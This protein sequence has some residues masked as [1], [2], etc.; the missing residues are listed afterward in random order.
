MQSAENLLELSLGEQS[1]QQSF[2]ENITQSSVEGL[3]LDDLADI[4]DGCL[5]HLSSD[6]KAKF[7]RNG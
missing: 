1:D 5:R 6:N 3:L 2:K 7:R 4:K